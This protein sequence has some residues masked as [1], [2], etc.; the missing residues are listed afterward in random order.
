MTMLVYAL[1][2]LGAVCGASAWLSYHRVAEMEYQEHLS[3]WI[4]DGRPAGSRA[5]RKDAAFIEPDIMNT[6]LMHS[7]KWALTS[8]KAMRM[9]VLMRVFTA[10]MLVSL[11][12]LFVIILV[13]AD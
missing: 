2:V 3:D 11:L 13:Y 7:P 1:G 6:W 4:E 9:L 10:I 12:G 5:S 8:K